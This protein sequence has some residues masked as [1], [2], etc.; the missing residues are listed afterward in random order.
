MSDAYGSERF[1]KIDVQDN[2]IGFTPEEGQ[3]IFDLFERLH[4][5]DKFPGT[6]IGLTICRRI[7]ENN[8]GFIRATGTPGNGARFELYFREI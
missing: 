3:R 7:M 8:R 1:H 2:G 4:G 5:R 6:G